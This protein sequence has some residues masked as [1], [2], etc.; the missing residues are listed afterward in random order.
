VG[1]HIHL[2]GPDLRRLNTQVVVADRRAIK[3]KVL[4]EIATPPEPTLQ[5]TLFQALVHEQALDYVLQKSTELGA[6]RIVLWNAART[7]TRFEGE[8]LIHK[9]E[10]WKKI[11]EESAKQCDRVQGPELE[12]VVNFE[13]MCERAKKMER[14]FVLDQNGQPLVYPSPDL[15]SPSPQGRGDTVKF[16]VRGTLFFS[17]EYAK[18]RQLN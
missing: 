2:Q 5:I 1:E 8:K 7:P 9:L 12:F 10:R 11:L 17:L 13:T 18:I 16:W 15:R 6:S 14:I 3:V 4:E